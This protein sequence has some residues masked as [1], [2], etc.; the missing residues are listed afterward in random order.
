MTIKQLMRELSKTTDIITD[1]AYEHIQP[2]YYIYA[3]RGLVENVYIIN[4]HQLRTAN[5]L[6]LKHINDKLLK[7]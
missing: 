1:F 6:T 5:S 2:H 3:R 4:E 7:F